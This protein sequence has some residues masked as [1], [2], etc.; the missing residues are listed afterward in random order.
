MSDRDNASDP[1][2][3][4]ELSDPVEIDLKPSGYQPS[5]AELK[6]EYDMPGADMDTLRDA[7]FRTLKTEKMGN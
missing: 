4:A 1:K 5:K 6:E 7:F 2:P 3:Y